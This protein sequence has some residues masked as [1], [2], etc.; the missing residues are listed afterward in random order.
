MKPVSVARVAAVA[1]AGLA[2]A[3]A[4]VLGP[5]LFLAIPWRFRWWIGEFTFIAAVAGGCAW[6]CRVNP[7]RPWPI[8]DPA[9]TPDLRLHRIL[10]VVLQ[11][12]SLSLVYAF[13]APPAHGGIFDWDWDLAWFDAVRQ[14]ILRHGEFP[15]WH[16]RNSGGFPL[17]AEPQVGLVSPITALVLPFGVPVGLRLAVAL[18]MLMSVEGARRLA[19]L[20]LADPWAV[21]VAAALYGWNGFIVIFTVVA[22]PLTLCHPF[23]PWLLLYAFQLD[24][25]P[26]AAALLGVVAAVS[27]LT[28]IQYPTVYGLMITA[29]VVACGFLGRP[30]EDRR[31]YLT[32]LGLAAG[33][34][35]A[36]AGWRLALTGHLM[37]DFPRR[38]DARVDYTP[39]MFLHAMLDRLVPPP[40]HVPTT[41]NWMHELAGYV[42]L[43]PVVAAVASLVGPWRWWHTLGFAGLALALGSRHAYQPS[44]WLSYFPVFATMYHVGRW[45]L[46]ALLGLALAA[47]ST[48]QVARSAGGWSRRIATALAIYVVGDLAVYAHQ[49][50]PVAYSNRTVD[51]HSPGPPVPTIVS[52]ERWEFGNIPQDYQATRLGYAVIEGYCPMLGYDRRRKTARLWR[53]HPGYVGEFVSEGR[54]I[55]PA[56]WSPGRIAF[57]RLKPG[58]EVEVNQNPSSYWLA[59]G[60]RL[61]PDARCVELTR[62]FFARADGRG[63]LVLEARPP[64]RVFWA[65]G[66]LTVAGVVLTAGCYRSVSRFRRGSA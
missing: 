50:L 66:F 45:R 42:G 54:A 25:G 1:A 47:G 21:A 27:I 3:V 61:F 36:L 4:V 49:C 65:A 19:R 17:A 56:S 43:V 58:Q 35:L 5:D 13:F 52:I 26:R 15:W 40:P 8:L 34:F 46:P 24:R 62:R 2:L 37:Y 12:I 59:N 31:R 29:A 63:V 22:P 38:H 7:P 44:F 39:Q 16:A 57:D 33:V 20:W 10:A 18:A 53:G 60:R 41:M 30:R 55:T 23:L 48:F 28:V 11:V 64:A 51:E 6:A 32:L 14:S 9:K